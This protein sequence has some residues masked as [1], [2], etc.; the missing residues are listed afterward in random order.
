MHI[1][2]I[3]VCFVLLWKRRNTMKIWVRVSAA[4]AVLVYCAAAFTGMSVL[5]VAPVFWMLLGILAADPMP[6]PVKQVKA[7]NAGKK[8]KD[9]A[10]GRKEAS[11][12]EQTDAPAQKQ[13]NAPSGSKAKKSKKKK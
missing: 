11:A 10:S 1:A 9:A 4:C 7:D 6:E 2:L 12:D 13:K 8:K 3:A 5:S